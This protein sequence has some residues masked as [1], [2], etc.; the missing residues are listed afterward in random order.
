MNRT[1]KTLI[2][3]GLTAI[4]GS[5]VIA[6]AVKAH[7][8]GRD[9]RWQESHERGGRGHGDMGR[10]GPGG[11]GGFAMMEQF[12]LN[13]DGNLTQAE[14]DQARKDKLA[15]FD[16]NKDGK[17]SLK[18]FE[19]LW[20]ET[21]REQMVRSFQRLDADGDATVTLDEYSKPYQ[22]MVQMR[23][24]NE[25]GQINQDDMHRRGYRGDGPRG[26][27]NGDGPKGPMNGTPKADK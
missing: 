4:V 13:K 18:E 9:G 22:R 26:P 20:L 11:A 27:A 25:D 1:T 10:G 8:G 7:E 15:K 19:A 23:D 6:G 3:V 14:I 24:R 5:A 16:A 2:I 12:D 21:T 17:L